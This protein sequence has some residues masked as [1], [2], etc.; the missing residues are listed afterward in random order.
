MI[1]IAPTTDKVSNKSGDRRAAYLRELVAMPDIIETDYP[2]EFVHLPRSRNELRFLRK[3]AV[4]R[5]G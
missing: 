1:A 3:K 4:K 2:S 5:I